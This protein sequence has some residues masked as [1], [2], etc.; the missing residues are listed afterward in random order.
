[1][2][3]EFIYC[4]NQMIKNWSSSSS[5]NNESYESDFSKDFLIDLKDLRIITERE[6]I[7]D[8]KKL[9]IASIGKTISTQSNTRDYK[10]KIQM[11]DASFRVIFIYY[12]YAEKIDKLEMNY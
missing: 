10:S 11:L 1:M 3:D 2:L 7:E 8:H 5:N 6:F 4:A 9:V 12:F